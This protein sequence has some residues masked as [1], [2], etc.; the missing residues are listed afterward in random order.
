MQVICYSRPS[1]AAKMSL[2]PF[3][4]AVI[5]RSL[6]NERLFAAW[7][8]LADA[9]A[10]RRLAASASLLS[11]AVKRSA[12][13]EAWEQER[14]KA[15]AARLFFSPVAVLLS[16][17]LLHLLHLRLSPQ[18]SRTL[19]LPTL[20][21]KKQSP[22]A[23]NDG[24]LTGADAVAFFER[25]GLPRPT[26]A[27]VWTLADAGRRG[28]L[29]R[30]SFAKAME[31]IGIAQ[32]SGT[33]DLSAEAYAGAAARAD[34]DPPAL[35]GVEA[36]AASVA[37]GRDDSGGG[38]ARPSPSGSGAPSP[39]QQ[40]YAYAQA[41]SSAAAGSPS[42]RQDNGK[43]PGGGGGKGSSQPSMK[44][45]TGVVDG[46]KQI[47]FSKGEQ[48]IRN[49]YRE[50]ESEREHEE[51]GEKRRRERESARKEAQKS[52]N[53][54][55]KKHLKNLSKKTFQQR[56]QARRGGLQV[57]LL[58]LGLPHRLRLRRQALGAA[59]GPVLDR[60]NDLYR[61]LAGEEI[62][63]SQHRAGTFDRPRRRHL[64]RA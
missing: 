30:R 27:K 50:R 57:R 14:K 52:P 19:S 37:G 25:S 9:G 34:L 35:E 55:K 24:K 62:P 59:A 20:L 15:A 46:L 16:L 1:I 31:L 7:F 61:A 29:D 8:Q 5:P 45:I 32:R 38:G 56:S 63:R 49:G 41:S 11:R 33:D 36:A 42:Q 40:Q 3:G 53:L 51:R 48:E 60:E 17:D 12:R 47:Y 43:R 23:D 4:E 28:F 13:D 22:S 64:A 21:Q 2:N 26:L 58:L 10:C 18:T 54:G 39:S 6:D 44:A